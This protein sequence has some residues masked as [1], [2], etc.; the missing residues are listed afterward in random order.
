MLPDQLLNVYLKHATLIVFNSQLYI[1][2]IKW[3]KSEYVLTAEFRQLKLLQC[4][5]DG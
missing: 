4:S 3:Q 5:M 1:A 2:F